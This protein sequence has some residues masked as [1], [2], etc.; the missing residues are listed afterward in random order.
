[1][2]LK[3]VVESIWRGEP[4][5]SPLEQ[6]LQRIPVLRRLQSAKLEKQSG[7]IGCH[8]VVFVQGCGGLANTKRSSVARMLAS[9][10][11]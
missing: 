6:G 4:Q 2:P 1:M 3:G 11:P 5:L 7:Q 8:G 10:F 9:G